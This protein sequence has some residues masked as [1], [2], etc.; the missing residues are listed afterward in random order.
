MKEE[1]SEAGTFVC[2]VLGEQ[3]KREEEKVAAS[4]SRRGRLVRN[5]TSCP[6]RPRVSG[7]CNCACLGRVLVCHEDRSQQDASPAHLVPIYVCQVNCIFVM[8][9]IYVTI[10]IYVMIHINVMIHIST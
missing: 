8:I 2:A 4:K 3:G 6:G 10:H 5:A 1:G 7:A 9:H